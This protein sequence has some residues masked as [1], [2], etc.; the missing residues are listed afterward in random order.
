MAISEEELPAIPILQPAEGGFVPPPQECNEPLVDITGLDGRILYNRTYY[1][2]KIF[3][4]LDHCFVRQGVWDRLKQVA[5]ELPQDHQLLIFDALRPLAVQQALYDELR[6]ALRIQRPQLSS[7]ELEEQ[8]DDYVAKPEKSFTHP[9][10]HTTG[11]AVDLTLCQGGVPLNMGTEFDD[12]SPAARTA[13]FEQGQLTVEEEVCR[14]NRRRLYQAMTR[15]GFVN[16]QREWW[17]YAYGER[18]WAREQGCAPIYGYCEMA[19]D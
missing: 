9:A 15:A 12:Y 16:Y 17:H 10:P 14:N 1:E 8:L 7:R 4:A 18:M 11:G 13:W 2:Q 5:D 3:G 19:D 6:R